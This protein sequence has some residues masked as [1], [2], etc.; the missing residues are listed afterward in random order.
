MRI[1]LGNTSR[2]A[3]PRR[4][5]RCRSSRPPCILNPI[6]SS[7][8]SCSA[9]PCCVPGHNAEAWPNRGRRLKIN[10]DP[11]TREVVARMHQEFHIN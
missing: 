1:N 9:W 8:I 7:P 2:Y 3:R 5:K 11:A 4:L 10:P 6:H